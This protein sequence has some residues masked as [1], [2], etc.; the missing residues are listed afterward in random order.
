M[1]HSLTGNVP[2]KEDITDT[3]NDVV[4]MSSSLEA[5]APLEDD[6]NGDIP[7]KKES[8]LSCK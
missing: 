8:A 5:A 1:C 6:I 4:F 7:S 3:K 2:P